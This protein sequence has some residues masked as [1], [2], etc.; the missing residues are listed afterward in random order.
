MS[1]AAR[2]AVWQ[3]SRQSGSHLTVLLCLAE[4][5][6]DEAGSLAWP[7]V[8][9]IATRCRITERYVQVILR[10]LV[11]ARELALI[12]CAGPRGVRRYRVTCSPNSSLVH[13]A[14]KGEP[15]FNREVSEHQPAGEVEFTGGVH[16]GSPR[17][18]AGFVGGVNAASPN[19][20]LEPVA[21]PVVEPVVG[22]GLR[23]RPLS[24]MD[25]MGRGLRQETAQQL[26]DSQIAIGKRCITASEFDNLKRV[27]DLR[28]YSVERLAGDIAAGE[29]C[30]YLA[31]LKPEH[32]P[33]GP[34][35]AAA[36]A[37]EAFG[38]IRSWQQEEPA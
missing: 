3:N 16:Q 2:D 37:S 24:I 38:G 26:V 12:D 35:L 28:G 18:E 4:H 13:P 17:G 21:E 33:P 23:P 36:R 15:G 14:A 32:V 1:R 27:A 5:Q 10:D 29:H 34:R 19:T 6:N 9:T 20:V 11:A 31:E 8:A 22:H 7:S 30:R 25:L